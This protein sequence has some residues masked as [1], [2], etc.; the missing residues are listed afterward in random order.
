MNDIMLAEAEI[1]RLKDLTVRH[2]GTLYRARRL[3]VR[4]ADTIDG[5][6]GD[7]DEDDNRAIVRE[8][9]AFLEER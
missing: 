8:I 5:L 2:I 1:Q 6:A 9:M 4:A 7:D 3:L